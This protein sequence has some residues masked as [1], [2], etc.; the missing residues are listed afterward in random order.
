MGMI[1]A[2]MA[3]GIIL[4]VRAI[5][6]MNFAQGDFLMLGAYISCALIVDAKLP[7]G[8]MIPVALLSFAAIALIFMFGVYWPLRK[9]SYP[10]A[11]VIATIGTSIVIKELVTLIWGS[12][13]RPIPS[14]LTD[15][16]TG[17]GLLLRIGD[18]RL[19]WQMIL[20]TLVGGA[21]IILVFILFEKLYCGRMMEAAAQDKYGAELLGIPAITTIAATYIISI[22]LASIAG[23]MVAP[24]FTVNVSLGTLQLRSFAGVIIGGMGNIKGAIMGALFVGVLES[25]ASVQFSAYKDA[26]VFIVLLVFLVVRPQGLFGE[27]ISDKA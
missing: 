8:L 22:A 15:A 17:G 1:Y 14:I 3:M 7:L 24:M 5:G 21:A 16:A 19:Q 25:F 12:L 27:K 9:A 4:L 6:V 23:F 10:A 11:I 20:T 26:V 2:L 13:P 18:V